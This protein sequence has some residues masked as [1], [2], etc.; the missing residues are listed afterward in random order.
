M[1]KFAIIVLIIRI[2]V[3]LILK[4]RKRIVRSEDFP[5]VKHPAEFSLRWEQ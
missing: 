4:S 5:E 2:I 1:F 3:E